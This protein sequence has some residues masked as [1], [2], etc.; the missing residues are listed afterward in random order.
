MRASSNLFET[1]DHRE[2]HFIILYRS[3][4]V[5]TMI[6]DGRL[7]LNIKLCIIYSVLGHFGCEN[8][9]NTALKCVIPLVCTSR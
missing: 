9:V 3:F 7:V 2:L 4:Y 5:Q 8:N 1:S 6:E